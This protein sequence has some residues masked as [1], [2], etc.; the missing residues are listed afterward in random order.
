MKHLNHEPRQQGEEPD[1]NATGER[2]RRS[3]L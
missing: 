1:Q 3:A 2:E